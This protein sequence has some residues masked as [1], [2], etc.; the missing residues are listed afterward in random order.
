MLAAVRESAI[1]VSETETVTIPSDF[2]VEGYG[3]KRVGSQ[4]PGVV[5]TSSFASMHLA[6]ALSLVQG[7][8]EAM[9]QEYKDL[10]TPEVDGEELPDLR[11]EFNAAWKHWEW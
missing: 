2:V 9:W 4:G 5:V 8:K 7:C 10:D 1:T 6:R 11:K 3:P